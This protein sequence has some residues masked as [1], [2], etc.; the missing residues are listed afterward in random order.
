MTVNLAYTQENDGFLEE[1]FMVSVFYEDMTKNSKHVYINKYAYSS[2][3]FDFEYLSNFLSYII[4]DIREREIR[5]A[6]VRYENMS[7][8]WN[9][10][11]PIFQQPKYKKM[12]FVDDIFNLSKRKQKR[13]ELRSFGKPLFLKN[14]KNQE[15]ALVVEAENLYYRCSGWIW[16]KPWKS[17]RCGIRFYFLV[18]NYMVIYQKIEGEWIRIYD[19]RIYSAHF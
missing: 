15:Y 1:E 3:N 13:A 17:F 10:N 6:F 5:E 9:E 14:L 18:A 12:I 2:E 19:M 7:N 4:P 11:A 16:K 8:I